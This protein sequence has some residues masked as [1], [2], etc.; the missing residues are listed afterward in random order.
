MRDFLNTFHGWVSGQLHKHAE[1]FTLT[2]QITEQCNL[3]CSYCYQIEKNCGVMSL[4]N[5]KKIFDLILSNDSKILDLI[6]LNNFD[7]FLVEFIGGEPFLEIDLIQQATEYLD[8]Q[9]KLLNHRWQ[10]YWNIYIT[11]NGTLYFNPKVQQYIFDWNDH[12]F[13]VISIDGNEFIHNLNRKFINNEGSYQYAI[14]AALHYFNTYHIINRTKF[15]L[16]PENINYIADGFINL[17]NL[18]FM[19]L[20]T[21]FALEQNWTY[22]N[23]KTF[24]NEMKKVANYIIFEH[25]DDNLVLP[26]YR[27]TF[28]QPESI[29]LDKN[30]CEVGQGIL[31]LDWQG[32]IYPCIRFMRTSLG[33]QR[34]PIILGNVNDINTIQITKEYKQ[35]Q[36]VTQQNI[37][38]QECL[39]CKISYGCFWCTAYNYQIYGDMGHRVTNICCMHKARILANCYFWNQYYKY[40]NISKHYKLYL[41]DEEALK[42]I[43]LKELQL[44]HQL[45]ED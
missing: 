18:G 45:I 22:D 32:N 11:T 15:V 26:I 31:A 10:K 21:N 35:I 43:S 13:L 4:D 38:K 39:N 8:Q 20:N 14:N 25:K 16:S 28:G 29:K 30:S 9:L 27:T 44:L 5:I 6:N 41:S 36:N 42:I 2:L 3:K 19:D 7:G 23:A 40:H 37:S 1:I 12:L 34:T 24:Y 17:I 33:N